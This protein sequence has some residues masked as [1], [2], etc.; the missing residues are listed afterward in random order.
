MIFSTFFSTQTQL[1]VE[2]RLIASLPMPTILTST[3]GAEGKTDAKALALAVT[4]TTVLVFITAQVLGE[5][6]VRRGFPAVTDLTVLNLANPE[7]QVGLVIAL[8][9]TVVAIIGKVAAGYFVFGEEPVDRLVLGVGMA[10]RGE[11][12]LVFAGLGAATG[13]LSASVNVAI[14]VGPPSKSFT[15]LNA[16]GQRRQRIHADC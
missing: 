1:I 10:P 16:Y 7:N 4:L 3:G 5:I 15:K 6:S 14:E 8:F 11:V 12:G 13:A 2:T 9:L